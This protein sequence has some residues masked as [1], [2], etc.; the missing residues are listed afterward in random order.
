MRIPLILSLICAAG[1]V[2][3]DVVK[4]SVKVD[5]TIVHHPYNPDMYKQKE[6]VAQNQS[7]QPAV[8][9]KQPDPDAV[10]VEVEPEPLSFTLKTGLLKPQLDSLVKQYLPGKM[11]YWGNYEGKH[12]WVGTATIKAPTVEALLNKITSSYGKPPKGIEWKIHINVVEFI[13][14]N[15]KI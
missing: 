10:A 5:P 6:E 7:P 4:R 2:Q 11:V 15:N 9:K 12:E 1:C 8:E 3:A 14:K 13:Y